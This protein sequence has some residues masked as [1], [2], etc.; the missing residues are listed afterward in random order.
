MGHETGPH[1]PLQQ[2]LGLE[3]ADD[4]YINNVETLGMTSKSETSR[5]S[6]VLVPHDAWECEKRE[7]RSG[8]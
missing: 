3:F 1:V 4:G 5:K 6:R 7:T 8:R 2:G